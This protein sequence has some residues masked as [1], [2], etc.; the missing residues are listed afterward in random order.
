MN[1]KKLED[2]QNWKIYV[3]RIQIESK[4]AHWTHFYFLQ[5]FQLQQRKT[6]RQLSIPKITM[7]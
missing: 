5:Q 6:T 3:Q 4:N 1:I 7:Q 2:E